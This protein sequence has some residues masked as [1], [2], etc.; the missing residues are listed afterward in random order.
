MEREKNETKVNSDVGVRARKS[1]LEMIER[2]ISAVG[3]DMLK[4]NREIAGL[5]TDFQKKPE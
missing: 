1:S 2:R 4:A 3:G 5:K